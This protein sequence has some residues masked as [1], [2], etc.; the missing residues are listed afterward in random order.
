MRGA[1]GALVSKPRRSPR[2]SSSGTSFPGSGWRCARRAIVTSRAKSCDGLDDGLGPQRA[3][4]VEYRCFAALDGASTI[5][6]NAHVATTS[7][8]DSLG[9]NLMASGRQ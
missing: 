7:M 4:R 6:T 8:Q 1:F 3:E 9:T 2:T 5:P